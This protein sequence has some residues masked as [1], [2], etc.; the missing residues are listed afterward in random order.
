MALPH[1]KVLRLLHQNASAI[2][3]V[4]DEV[5]SVMFAVVWR[6]P[7]GD[8]IPVGTAVFRK[9]DGELGGLSV[10]PE[11]LMLCLQQLSKLG[12]QITQQLAGSASTFV[13]MKEEINDLKERLRAYEE[14]APKKEAPRPVSDDVP[15]GL[16]PRAGDT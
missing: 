2:V 16:A 4:H 10:R 7:L 9:A 11:N 1:E 14:A 15:T 6:P 8:G 12:K 13:A 3:D 5:L